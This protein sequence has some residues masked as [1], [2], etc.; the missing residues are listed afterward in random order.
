MFRD[1]TSLLWEATRS[2]PMV[3]AAWTNFET[4]CSYLLADSIVKVP[5]MAESITEGTLKQFSK[6]MLPIFETTTLERTNYVT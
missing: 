2:E 6:R 4:N 5:N 3:C 1:S